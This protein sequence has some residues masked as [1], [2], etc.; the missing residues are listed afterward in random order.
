MTCRE[1]KSQ[2]LLCYL[3]GKQHFVENSHMYSLQDLIDVKNK[4]LVKFLTG[5]HSTFLKHIK[6][7]CQV[8]KTARPKPIA[9]R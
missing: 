6:D 9:A 5:I 1:A 3:D 4:S 2:K 7:E 8:T